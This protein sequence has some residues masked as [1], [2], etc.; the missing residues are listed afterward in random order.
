MYLEK[1]KKE[2][3]EPVNGMNQSGKAETAVS[4]QREDSVGHFCGPG[5]A[6]MALPVSLSIRHQPNIVLRPVSS[7]RLGNSFP[8]LGELI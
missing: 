4:H 7:L 1:S 2:I 5:V 8:E 3:Q 6:M